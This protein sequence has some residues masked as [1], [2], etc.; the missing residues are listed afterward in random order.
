MRRS[1]SLLLIAVIALLAALA[2]VAHYAPGAAL[3]VNA[4]GVRGWP[5]SVANSTARAFDTSALVVPWRG[6]TINARL[7]LPRGS[8]NRAV[9]LVPGVHAGG[10][11]E[12]R[13]VKFA[14]DL[15]KR[16]FA[17]LTI[18]LPDL[19]QYEVTPGTTDMIE[20]AGLWLSAQRRYAPDGRIG[21]MGIS[22]GGGLTLVAAGRPSLR[23]RVA[24]VLSFGGH[25]DFP[26]TLKFLC[27]GTQ[28][29]GQYRRPHDYGV[30]I[31]LLGSADRVVPPEQVGILRNG[32]R[33]FL[34]ASH[35]AMVD[36]PRAERIFRQAVEMAKTMPEPSATLMRYV[37]ERNVKALGPIL[38]PY[39]GSYG[40]D[41]ALS[42]D[43]A[44]APSAPVYLLHGSDDTVIPAV[45]SEYLAKDLERRGARVRLLLT[46]LITHA[47][48]DRPMDFIE[49][50]K[51]I[52]FWTAVLHH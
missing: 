51:M 5:E 16:G 6:G 9:V 40:G 34:E 21:L 43:R 41:P 24:F 30:V 39:V 29:D 2:A 28:A 46:P 45:E 33:T 49:L 3:V 13:L 17:M 7:Y 8:I 42:P 38:L 36:Q 31:I 37:N 18:E 35:V 10:I 15:A 50:W 4:A 19:K 23:D 11:D 14:G 27:T 48:M 26:R 1:R 52:G 32:I 25:G 47:E 44:P 22:F 12:P 20:D